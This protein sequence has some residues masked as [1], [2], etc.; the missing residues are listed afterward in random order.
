ME[1]IFPLAL[2]E[3]NNWIPSLLLF[4]KKV[5]CWE[6]YLLTIIF[7]WF[8]LAQSDIFFESWKI[9]LTLKNEIFTLKKCWCN[10]L[11]YSSS[12]VHIMYIT[13]TIR[14]LMIKSCFSWKCIR[15]QQISRSSSEKKWTCI[16]HF[17]QYLPPSMKV[18]CKY[19]YFYSI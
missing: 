7:N 1:E 15:Y 8:I 19:L 10:D 17:C 14:Y 18:Y 5:S 11:N 12:Y 4:C 3:Y 9:F 6:I 13:F 2:V 16:W